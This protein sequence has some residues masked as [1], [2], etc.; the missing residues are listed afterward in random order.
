MNYH[1]LIHYATET[2]EDETQEERII[3]ALDIA[4]NAGLFARDQGHTPPRFL[5]YKLV[6]LTKQDILEVIHDTSICIGGVAI[7]MTFAY[8]VLAN[9]TGIGFCV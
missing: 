5:R 4:Y 1:D 8:W 3:T 6:N 7:V 2:I 9:M